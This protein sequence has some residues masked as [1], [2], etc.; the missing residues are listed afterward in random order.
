MLATPLTLCMALRTNG[1]CHCCVHQHS[2]DAV[3]ST[4]SEPSKLQLN[5]QPTSVHLSFKCAMRHTVKWFAEMQ[6]NYICQPPS[7]ILVRLA[8]KKK[9]KSEVLAPIH[10]LQTL[11]Q[12]DDHCFLSLELTNHLCN[13]LFEL[14]AKDW[15]PSHQ[16]AV[17]TKRV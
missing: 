11:A 7:I 6:I 3:C 14:P 10:S 9:K 1:H 13:D 17:P 4:F 8:K 12:G 2:P 15:R 5:I 16:S